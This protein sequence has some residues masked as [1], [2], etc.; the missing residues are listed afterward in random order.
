[1][2][3]HWHPCL[4]SVDLQS[5]PLSQMLRASPPRTAGLEPWQ[6][7]WLM[8]HSWEMEA[9]MLVTMPGGEGNPPEAQ[10]AWS[11]PRSFGTITFPFLLI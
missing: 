5:Y 7:L 4:L 1:M 3:S 2:V 10:L 8:H 11:L 6:W 9:G